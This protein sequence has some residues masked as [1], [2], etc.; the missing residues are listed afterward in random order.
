MKDRDD[1]MIPCSFL[2]PHYSEKIDGY[3][4]VVVIV[5]MMLIFLLQITGYGWLHRGNFTTF[6]LL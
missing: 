1:Q 3:L 5:G 6:V 2:H 4:S